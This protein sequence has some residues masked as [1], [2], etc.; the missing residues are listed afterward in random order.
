MRNECRLWPSPA[1][2]TNHSELKV[3][4]QK[5]RGDQGDHKFPSKG[6]DSKNHKKH[7]HTP[8]PEGRT[9]PG[10]RT[11]GL[12]SPAPPSVVQ[13]QGLV[14]PRP[15][16]ALGHHLAA[17]SAPLGSAARCQAPPSSQRREEL[18]R[19]KERGSIA[20]AASRAASAGSGG[21]TGGRDLKVGAGLGP[22]V[23]QGQKAK[24]YPGVLFLDAR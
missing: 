21:R 23:A 9:R 13:E 8:I 24:W 14:L 19:T 15:G 16:W 12:P 2:R 10:P 17:C 22:E 11:S 6:R 7:L 4:L 20:R 3:R 5:L 1:R 18:G